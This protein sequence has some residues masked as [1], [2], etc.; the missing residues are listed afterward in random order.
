MKSIVKSWRGFIDP[1]LS[2]VIERRLN[3]AISRR[4]FLAGGAAAG[5]LY[6]LMSTDYF[7]GLTDKEQ[8]ELI[9]ASPEQLAGLEIQDPEYIKA[10]QQYEKEMEGR[11]SHKDEYEG[12]SDSEIKQ[13]Q[14]QKVGALMIAP[15]QLEDNREWAMAP[16]AQNQLQG[17]Y[18]YA[19]EI[20][21]DLIGE[22]NP[23]IKKA[24]DQAYDFYK[25]F[26]ITRLHQYVY[27]RPEFFSYTSSSDANEGKLFATIEIDQ[28]ERDY[29]TGEMRN[30]KFRKLPL[31]WTLAQRV[32]IDLVSFMDAE[33]EQAK[34]QEE[35]SVIFEKYGVV[36]EYGQG[37]SKV[38][39]Q[40]VLKKV[41]RSA[42]NALKR[43]DN[44]TSVLGKHSN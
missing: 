19:S 17:Y 21:L 25:G 36:T 30:I 29:L 43:M 7:K 23:E 4:Q 8:D 15:A 44:E 34:T 42:G 33:L 12:L 40:D 2:P 24:M 1:D 26:G 11:E 13:L 5:L 10:L 22:T 9:E 16:V 18:A 39:K 31:A 35:A 3:E 41:K 27:G 6:A 28:K 38:S 20:D 37:Y 32:L 14:F